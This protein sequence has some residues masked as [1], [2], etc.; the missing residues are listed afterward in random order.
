MSQHA[1][2]T[3]DLLVRKGQASPTGGFAHAGIEMSRRLPAPAKLGAPRTNGVHA[4]GPVGL[5]AAPAKSQPSRAAAGREGRVA[6]TFRLDRERHR[7][8]KV[9][10]ARNQQ[11]TQEILLAALDAYLEA[12]GADCA[13]LRGEPEDCSRN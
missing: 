1:K 5:S 3:G 10:C 8:L 7:R 9:F 11:T 13:C 2:L 6:L 12:C 4:T